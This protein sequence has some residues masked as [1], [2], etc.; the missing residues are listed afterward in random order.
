MR[1]FPIA[2]LALAIAALICAA[3]AIAQA[4]NPM[5][6]DSWR[7]TS[8]VAWG[9]GVRD[10]I[11]AD[12]EITQATPAALTAALTRY[13]AH[14]G[15]IL[16]LNSPGGDLDAGLAMGRIIRS[17]GLWTSVGTAVPLALGPTPNVNPAYFPYVQAPSAPPFPGYCY[18]SC[19]LAFLGGVVRTVGFTSD[20]GVHRFYFE[21]Q[22][23]SSSEGVAEGEKGMAEIVHYVKEM[24]VDPDFVLEMAKKGRNATTHLTEQQMA[25][26]HV[27][28]PF[29]NTEWSIRQG[30][31]S[32]Y[33]DGETTDASGKR[34]D[35]LVYCGDD[36]EK[37]AG[38]VVM[39]S[40]YVDGAGRV[41]PASFVRGVTNYN[42]RLDQFGII[43]ANSDKRVL[44]HAF[45]SATSGRIGATIGFTL[46]QF[47]VITDSHYM[48]F[49][50]YNPSSDVRFFGT[51]VTVDD[52]DLD[53]FARHCLPPAN[54]DFSLENV[55]SQTLTSVVTRVAGDAKFGANRLSA[56]LAPNA[57]ATIIMPH[58]RGCQFDLMM[59]YADKQNV[60]EYNVDLCAFGGISVASPSSPGRATTTDITIKNA[61]KTPITA[62]YIAPTTDKY[63]G[64]NLLAGKDPS[65]PASI[66]PGA[67]GKFS[68]NIAQTCQFDMKVQ[69]T[70][71]AIEERGN[72]NFCVFDQQSFAAPP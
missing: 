9:Q 6:F 15:T 72:Q 22:Q 52:L 14:P 68:F 5:T 71:G 57:K 53:R 61:G 29:W 10:Y 65:H 38:D 27:I 13:Q 47:A 25:T 58:Y 23:P 19:T 64:S 24:G 60:A 51:T 67:T 17:H 32:F 45:V 43:L 3:P 30:S 50:F 8:G 35:V 62:L 42:I 18:S 54:T 40:V 20:Y 59:Q 7:D 33:Y 4:Q 12:G 1:H 48:G 31:G 49:A 63:W 39:M 28:T 2:G 56:A 69:Y 16:V 34:D 46:N 36:H 41:D 66:A 70:G 26:L 11:F 44:D 37:A 55:G 21:G